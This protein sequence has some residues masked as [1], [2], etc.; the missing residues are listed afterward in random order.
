MRYE[1]GVGGAAS[2]LRELADQIDR[3]EVLVQT[4]IQ[5]TRNATD[6]FEIKSL[7]VRFAERKE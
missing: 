6:D 4:V 7:V 5:N 1:F 2:K 3:E